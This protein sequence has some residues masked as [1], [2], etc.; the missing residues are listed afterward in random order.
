MQFFG[1]VGLLIS[2][3]ILV[4]L[5]II[6]FGP[7]SDTESSSIKTEI[8]TDSINAAEEAASQMGTQ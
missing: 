8:Y 6:G 1:L 4:W 5:F 2:I 7:T 3:M